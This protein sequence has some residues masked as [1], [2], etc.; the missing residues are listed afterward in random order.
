MLNSLSINNNELRTIRERIFINHT[1]AEQREI[2]EEITLLNLSDQSIPSIFLFRDEFMTGL[3]ILDETDKD[4][5]LYP[6][7]LTRQLIMLYA[8]SEP[9]DGNLHKLLQRMES[10]NDKVYVLWIRLPEGEE[11]KPNQSKIIKLSYKNITEPQKL[12]WRQDPFRNQKILFTVPRFRTQRTKPKESAYDTFYIISVPEGY[13]IDHDVLKHVELNDKNVEVGISGKVYENSD[14]HNISIRSPAGKNE[15]RF[16]MIYDI[17]PD[18]SDRIFFICSVAAIIAFSAI[19][20]IIAYEGSAFASTNNILK[21]IY[22]NSDVLL[23]GI[24]TGALTAIGFM[25]SSSTNRTRFWFFI[26]VVISAA[27]FF[28]KS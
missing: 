25:K 21:K 12:P 19:V 5:V 23:G 6:N 4:L 20:S 16:D 14:K 27:G 26:S 9:A 13:M 10:E 2:T 8:R 17:V 22:D 3:R 11:I 1:T 24:V 18:K 15:T 28:F 7:D